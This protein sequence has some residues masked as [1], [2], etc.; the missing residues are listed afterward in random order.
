MGNT[1]QSSTKLGT[2]NS[3][4][5]ANAGRAE[6]QPP[7]ELVLDLH[8]PVLVLVILENGNERAADGEAGAVQRVQRLGL[9]LFVPEAR[10]HA[11]RLER[12][13]IGA[14]GNFA[15]GALARQPDLD[16]VG[17]GSGETHVAGA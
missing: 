1:T 16:V 11:A 5:A 12:L 6:V 10:V 15:V 9:A 7:Q 4:P 3:A 17:L 13:E 14:G 2:L 8:G